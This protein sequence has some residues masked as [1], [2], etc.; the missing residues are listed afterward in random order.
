[1]EDPFPWSPAQ[2]PR[3]L[4]LGAHGDPLRSLPLAAEPLALGRGGSARAA[5]GLGYLLPVGLPALPRPLGREQARP[6][7]R[8]RRGA[9]VHVAGARVPRPAA[10]SNA[11]P[12]GDPPRRA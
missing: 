8:A 10:A 11:V 7:P 1:M 4:L 6:G 3:P 5:H 12:P 2:P 9:P